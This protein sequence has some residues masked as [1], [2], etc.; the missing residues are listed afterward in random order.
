MNKLVHIVVN[1]IAGSGKAKSVS[2]HVFHKFREVFQSSVTM[3]FTESK[4]DATF[5][6]REAILK[7]ASVVVVIGGDGTI[8]EAINGFFLNGQPVNSECVLGIINCGTGAGLAK[9]LHLPKSIDQQIELI[10]HSNSVKIDLGYVSFTGLTNQPSTKFFVSECQTGIGSEVVSRVGK[11]HK[12]LGGRLAFGYVSTLQA[13][14]LKSSILQIRYDDEPE[15]TH[16]LLGLV[17]GNGVVC[18][19]GMKLTPNAQLNDGLFDVLLI[20]EMHLIKRLSNLSKVYSGKHLLSPYF[21]VRR[22]QKISV[23]GQ[24]NSTFE[25]DGEHLGSLPFIA[26]VFPCAINVIGGKPFISNYE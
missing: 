7:G 25:A 2:N 10:I 14:T 26:S 1:P 19:G 8:F 23:K 21:S 6:T 18:G 13:F 16:H 12:L 20:R 3:T 4:D 22:C 9:T 24:R 15:E 11:R 17:V 5:I